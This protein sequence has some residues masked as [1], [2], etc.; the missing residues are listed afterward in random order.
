[1]T[2]KSKN[3]KI[4]I[5]ILSVLTISI[6]AYFRYNK[7]EQNNRFLGAYDLYKIQ[8]SID[9]K[10]LVPLSESNHAKSSVMIGLYHL[11]DG[12][13]SKAMVLF[14]KA[15][16]DGEKIYGSLNLA[17]CAGEKFLKLW[18]MEN[19]KKALDLAE[20]GD[21]LMQWEIANAIYSGKYV[22]SK[23]T[24]LAFKLLGESANLGFTKSCVLYGLWNQDGIGTKSNEKEAFKWYKKAA[25]NGSSTGQSLLGYYYTMGK[26]GQKISYPEALKYYRLAA[27]KGN[28][29]AQ[30]ALAYM[31][32]SGMGV[33][34][35]INESL[36]WA[37][38]ASDNG[39]ATAAEFIENYNNEQEAKRQ[40]AADAAQSYSQNESN[41]SATTCYWCNDRYRYAGYYV[42]D[43]DDRIKEVD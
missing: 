33:T 43:R 15:I 7:I 32:Q 11:K 13:T 41:A 39:S 9:I 14:Q 10:T 31:Y 35:D 40:A 1:M 28:S 5:T 19:Y 21:W 23:D 16:N 37:K 36:R 17:V 26:G 22:E 30:I 6:I 12:D 3:I 2:K 34:A 42:N 27:A 25:E 20:D 4:L 18:W 8:D 38:L 24:T 29:S